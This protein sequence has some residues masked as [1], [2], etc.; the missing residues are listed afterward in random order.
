MTSNNQNYVRYLCKY[1]T[2]LT[3]LMIR[4][5][6][7]SSAGARDDDPLSDVKFSRVEL[8]SYPGPP[9]GTV[10]KAGVELQEDLVA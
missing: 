3:G 1:T 5:V 10:Y 2:V 4:G 9:E 6:L 7:A 8:T